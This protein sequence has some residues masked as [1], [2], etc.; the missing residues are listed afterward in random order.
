MDVAIPRSVRLVLYLVTS[1]G[2][3][4]VTYLAARGL[5]GPDEIGLWTGFTAL[6]AAMAGFNISPGDKPA[7]AGKAT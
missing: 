1:I 2:S 4:L 6:I 5:V 7:A 3:L